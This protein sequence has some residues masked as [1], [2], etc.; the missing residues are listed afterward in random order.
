MNLLR[1]TPSS[2]VSPSNR[3]GF[4]FCLIKSDQPYT[5]R[6]NLRRPEAWCLVRAEHVDSA[7]PLER[8]DYRSSRGYV[9]GSESVHNPNSL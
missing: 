4:R 7:E 2:S 8:G 5:H 1:A 9:A 3:L 6:E